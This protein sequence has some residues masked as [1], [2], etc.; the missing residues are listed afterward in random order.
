MKSIKILLAVALSGSLL[1][2]CANNPPPPPPAPA[3][4][5]AP[6]PTTTAPRVRG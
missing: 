6:A 4:A 1:A 5:P 3:A 2:A